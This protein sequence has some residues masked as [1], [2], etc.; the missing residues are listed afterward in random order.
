MAYIADKFC[1][2]VKKFLGDAYTVKWDKARDAS[3][4]ELYEIVVIANETGQFWRGK[5]YWDDFKAIDHEVTAKTALHSLFEKNLRV[6][7]I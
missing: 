2:K 1:S 6:R 3:N 5:M 4:R 7:G